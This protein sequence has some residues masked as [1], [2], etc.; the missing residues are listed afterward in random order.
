[1]TDRKKQNYLITQLVKGVPA[2]KINVA[3]YLLEQSA[4]SREKAL[5]A[6]HEENRQA[7]RQREREARLRSARQD[8]ESRVALIHT[9]SPGVWAE[10]EKEIAQEGG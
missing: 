6:I 8:A 3:R 1:M 9:F 10:V 2:E 5:E 4:L 7:Q